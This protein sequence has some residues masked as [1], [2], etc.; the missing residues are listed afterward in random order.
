MKQPRRRSSL[1]PE[2][3]W[4]THNGEP[5]R[6]YVY[7]ISG[8]QWTTHT[9]RLRNIY[10]LSRSASLINSTV[11]FTEH[12]AAYFLVGIPVVLAS[13]LYC[14][15]APRLSVY[16]I[17]LLTACSASQIYGRRKQL[18]QAYWADIPPTLTSPF[19]Q[20]GPFDR[21]LLAPRCAPAAAPRACVSALARHYSDCKKCISIYTV[22]IDI[23]SW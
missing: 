12:K 5:R 23:H 16:T 6:R 19:R 7:A 4:L 11:A 22:Y 18:T 20:R 1:L 8:L 13:F 9:L 15:R 2:T 3:T 21:F 14:R 17:I 10:I